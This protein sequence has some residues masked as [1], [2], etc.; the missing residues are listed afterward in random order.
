MTT[1]PIRILVTG[2]SGFPG[3]AKNPTAQM[4]A[5]LAKHRSRLF[6]AG[7][8]IDLVTLPVVYA[9]I[10]PRLS[11]LA[12]EIKPD[13]ILHFGL[14]AR[15]KTLCVETRALNRVSQL[16]YDAAGAQAERRTIALGAPPV[17]RSTLPCA[18]V[19]TA[20][21]RAGLGAD[22]SIDAGDYVCNQTLFLSLSQNH[23]PL[24]GFI[25]V[26]RL[27]HRRSSAPNSAR[28]LRQGGGISSASSNFAPKP[29]L[30]LEDATRAA[31][32]AILALAPKLPRREAK[33]VS[34]PCAPKN[35]STATLDPALLLA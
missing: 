1:R 2:F 13:A 24:V 17:A 26:P 4:I 14:A 31:V 6:R 5:A 15:R 22:L 12:Q 33:T 32:I 29:R 8:S 35:S 10:A 11:R 25:H 18:L 9:Q 30:S 28:R 3:A 34:D 19:A 7:I 16:H 27:G 20:L 21:R 23:A